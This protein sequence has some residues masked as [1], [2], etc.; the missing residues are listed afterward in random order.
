MI[1]FVFSLGWCFAVASIFVWLG[2]TIEIGALLAGVSLSMSPYHYQISSRIRPLRDFF[3]IVFFVL[4]GSTISFS[5]LR[6]VILPTIALSLFVL[7][8][9]PLI[10]MVVMALLG[11]RKRNNF[12]TGISLAQI[13]EFSFVFIAAVAAAGY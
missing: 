2:F 11:H 10:V 4:L 5:S 6:P 13:S 1:L 12:F 7:L 8:I 3:I 9:K